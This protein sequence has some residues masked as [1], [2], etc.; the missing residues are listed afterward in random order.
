MAASKR[1]C[2]SASTSPTIPAIVL[3]VDDLVSCGVRRGKHITS[4]SSSSKSKT[5]TIAKKSS[6]PKLSPKLASKVQSSKK[7]K[8]KQILGIPSEGW[9]HYV[10]LEWP[11]LPNQSST[12]SISQKFS[13]Q[14]NMTHH[15][16]V[17]KNEMSPMY[18][19]YFD[20]VHNIIL[21]RKQRRTVLNQDKNGHALPCGFWMASIF[22]A[23]D[24]PVQVWD[25]QT[26]KDVVGRVN[27]MA[28]HVS[29][30]RLDTPL[31]RLQ[32]QLAEKENELVT[33]MTTHQI[34]KETWEARVVAL[35]HELA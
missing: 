17:G 13:S 16:C 14:P 20:V 10:K 21:H 2:A 11:P 32:H 33:M 12:L 22:E 35:Q 28:L 4:Q 24:M 15:R 27:R 34:E 30:R 5:S 9:G 31:Q 18:Q 23:F 25:S 6:F 26:V 19:L 7:F 1:T 29:M 8:K 3:C